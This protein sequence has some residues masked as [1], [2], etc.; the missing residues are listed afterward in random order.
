MVAPTVMPSKMA[1]THQS[2]VGVASMKKITDAV[3]AAVATARY[4]GIAEL[5]SVL[6][7]KSDSA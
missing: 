2:R 7:P 6:R 5:E 3:V 4:V 1:F